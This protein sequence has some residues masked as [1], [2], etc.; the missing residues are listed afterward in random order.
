MREELKSKRGIT[1]IALIITIIVM[2]ILVGVTVNIALNGNLF[3]K[4]KDAAE[5]T[6]KA[7]EKEELI[8]FALSEYDV[9]TLSVNKE[10]LET[11]VTSNGYTI[12]ENK[13][14]ESKLVVTGKSKTLWQIILKT[15]EVEPYSDG[16]DEETDLEYLK[17]ILETKTNDQLVETGIKT[18]EWDS[19]DEEYYYEWSA[20]SGIVEDD[21]YNNICF[22]TY[23]GVKYNVY[24]DSNEET[25]IRVDNYNLPYGGFIIE[26]DATGVI[27]VGYKGEEVQELVIPDTLEVE[28]VTYNVYK[29]SGDFNGHMHECETIVIGKNITEIE[30]GAFLELHALKTI[31]NKA[32][33]EISGS[34]WG[35]TTNPE[36]INQS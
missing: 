33:A 31:V 5:G 12:D 32:T 1:L 6:Q 15:A 20:S 30:D 24:Y 17:R 10:A 23:K 4:A 26:L 22:I 19:K 14:S 7:I 8:S 28:G 27:I 13:T 34:P 9:D 3:N 25:I 29:I 36:I 16:N 18:K 2:L 35:S 11:L 21:F